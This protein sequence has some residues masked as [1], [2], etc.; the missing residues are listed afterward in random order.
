VVGVARLV[1]I[2]VTLAVVLFAAVS[3]FRL[4]GPAPQ[5]ATTVGFEA[6]YDHQSDTTDQYMVL[7]H[8]GGET[9]DLENLK[10][11]VRPGDQRVVNP[12]IESGGRSRAARRRST[13]RTPTSARRRTR[14]PSTSTTN[15][16][17]NRSPS[18]RFASSE[19]SPSRW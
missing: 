6:T 10:V 16:A 18:R 1:A 8:E 7:H 11:V 3:G 17:A 4:S 15:R 5:A 12:E 19:T 13:S 14:R 9:I 2:A